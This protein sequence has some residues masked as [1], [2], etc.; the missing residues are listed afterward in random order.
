MKSRIV[1]S[2]TCAAF[3]LGG[4]YEPF[5]NEDLE[6]LLSTPQALS[7][8]VP[9]TNTQSLRTAQTGEDGP[10]KFYRD[11]L[12]SAQ[13]INDGLFAFLEIVEF[14]SDFPPTVRED[15][16]RIWG[17]FPADDNPDNTIEIALVID[18]SRTATVARFVSTATAAAETSYSYSLVA[19]P[20]GTG[21]E[22]WLAI[23]GGQSHPRP[24]GQE[25]QTG[26]MV[27]SFENLRILD[28]EN[29]SDPGITVRQQFD[30]LSVESRVVA[31]KKD[32]GP[33]F[34]VTAAFIHNE[35]QDGTGSFI[36]AVVEDQLKNIP[37]DE[38]L[39]IGSRWLLGGRGRAD[40]AITSKGTP[41]RPPRPFAAVSEC[42]NDNFERVFLVSFP[43]VEEF[44]PVG[45]VEDCGPALLQSNFPDD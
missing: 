33:E 22:A 41:N 40:V 18:R 14:I 29:N 28:P 27:V 31:D 43:Q 1:C 44:T 34:E 4:C 7:I 21:D 17:P 25:G 26:R 15:D 2:L 45:T 13:E 12:K 19:R 37:G 5:S 3:A 23:L 42:W 16:R 24:E 8:D 6:F 35:E 9:A 36:F 10:A 32:A 39:Y 11:T 30:G 20:I 38:V